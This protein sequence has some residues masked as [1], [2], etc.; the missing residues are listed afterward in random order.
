LIKGSSEPIRQFI[1]IRSY[2]YAPECGSRLAFPRASAFV[3]AA[4]ASL[5]PQRPSPLLLAGRVLARFSNARPA[6]TLGTPEEED[7]EA[8]EVRKA[9]D[10]SST[11]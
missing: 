4:P 8:A 1:T 2:E 10:G 7:R 11:S 3:T 9:E 6:P 5:R